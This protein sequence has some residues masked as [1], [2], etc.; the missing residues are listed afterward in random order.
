MRATGNDLKRRLIGLCLVGLFVSLAILPAQARW[1]KYIDADGKLKYRKVDDVTGAPTPVVDPTKISGATATPDTRPEVRPD[2][3]ATGSIRSGI[4]VPPEVLTGTRV[5]P[6]VLEQGQPVTRVAS[7]GTPVGPFVLEAVPSTQPDAQSAAPATQPGG[8]AEVPV[9]QPIAGAATT[10]PAAPPVA[11]TPRTPATTPAAQPPTGIRFVFANEPL[12]NV[13]EFFSRITGLSIL[14]SKPMD[15]Q[16]TVTFYSP[17]AYTVPEALGVLNTILITRGLYLKIESD[18]MVLLPVDQVKSTPLPVYQG[19]LPAGKVQPSEIV[20]VIMPVGRGASMTAMQIKPLLS[21]FGAATA[22]GEGN[23]VLTDTAVNIRNAQNLLSLVMAG[24]SSTTRPAVEL[25]VF[26]MKNI[27]PDEMLQMIQQ[28]IGTPITRTENTPEGPKTIIERKMPGPVVADRRTNSLLVLAPTDDLKLISSIIERLDVAGIPKMDMETKIFTLERVDVNRA[29]DVIRNAFSGLNDQRQDSMKRSYSATAEIRI[30]V[31]PQ[32]RRLIVTA[33]TAR[34]TDIVKLI[35]D[36]E[37]VRQDTEEQFRIVRL[38]DAQANQVA[39]ALRQFVPSQRELRLDIAEDPRHNTLMLQSN[40]TVMMDKA[41]QLIAKIDPKAGTTTKPEDPLAKTIRIVELIAVDANEANQHIQA[42]LVASGKLSD[43]KPIIDCSSDGSAMLVSC[44]DTQWPQIKALI[45]DLEKIAPNEKPVNEIIRLNFQKP[46]DIEK[47]VQQLFGSGGSYGSGRS[48]R[49][50]RQGGSLKTIA[51]D[52]RQVLIVDATPTVMQQVKDL[53]KRLDVRGATADVKA[54]ETRTYQAGSGQQALQT[55]ESLKKHLADKLAANEIVATFNVDEPTATIFVSTRPQD[56][57]TIE[58]KLKEVMGALAPKASMAQFKVEHG[59]AAQMLSLISGV[60]GTRPTGKGAGDDLRV[61][62]DERT[63]SIIAWGTKETLALVD[64]TI[65][66]L[67]VPAGQSNAQ[68]FRAIVLDN[69]D[70]AQVATTL[71]SLFSEINHDRQKE[72]QSQIRFQPDTVSGRLY[73]IADDAAFKQITVLT[74]EIEK[75]LADKPMGIRFVPVKQGDPSAISQTVSQLY[76]R[77]SSRTGQVS[78]PQGIQI[79]PAPSSRSI[80]IKGDP[81]SV[82]EIALMIEKLDTPDTEQQELRT[83]ECA[84]GKQAQTAKEALTRAFAVDVQA[85][86][87][88]ASFEAEPDSALL[89]VTARKD[90]LVRIEAML[91][92]LKTRTQAMATMRQIALKNAD[93]RQLV[94][95]IEQVVAAQGGGVKLA[96]S[97]D[98]RFIVASGSPKDVE[99]AAKLAADFDLPDAVSAP[100]IR[101]LVLQAADPNA[102]AATLSDVFAVTNDLRKQMK[103]PEIRFRG[104]PATGQLFV[105]ADDEA[106]AQIEPVIKKLDIKGR[107]VMRQFATPDGNAWQWVAMLQN[108][109]GS[110][111]GGE[112]LKLGADPMGTSVVAVGSPEQLETVNQLL[113]AARTEN[114]TLKIVKLTTGDAAQMAK[115]VSESLGISGARGGHPGPV[116]AGSGARVTPDTGTNSLIVTG[117]AAEVAAVEKLVADLDK[118]NPNATQV[119]FVK[120]NNMYPSDMITMLTDL[121]GR[122]GGGPP[123]KVSA[124][125]AGSRLVVVTTPTHFETVSK[126]IK[127]LDAAPADPVTMHFIPVLSGKP[128]DIVDKIKP[129]VEA[130]FGKHG[131]TLTPDPITESVIFTGTQEQY[132]YVDSLVSELCKGATSDEG[133]IVTTVIPLGKEASATRMAEAIRSLHQQVEGTPVKVVQFQSGSTSAG[134]VIKDLSQAQPLPSIQPGTQAPNPPTRGSRSRGATS[135]PEGN[136]RS[137]ASGV[138]GYGLMRPFCRGIAAMMLGQT[139]PQPQPQPHPN[140]DVQPPPNP[141]V[142]GPEKPTNGGAHVGTA[143]RM[144]RTTRPESTTPPTIF[145]DQT[146]NSLIVQGTGAQVR[147]IQDLIDSLAE[148]TAGPDYEF[149]VYKLSACPPDSMAD[150]LE[151][152][153]NGRTTNAAGQPQVQIPQQPQQPQQGGNTGG[154][155]GRT[156]GG[157]TGGANSDASG[158][159]TPQQIQ[160]Q[161]MMQ[162]QQMIQQQ[163]QQQQR[164][165]RRIVVVPDLRTN[166]IIVKA[167]ANDFAII[168]PVV[169]AMDVELKGS[170]LEV[171]IFALQNIDAT[172]A[173]RNLK[174]LFRLSSGGGGTETAKELEALREQIIQIAKRGGGNEG[175][176]VKLINAGRMTITANQA[177]NTVVVAAPPEGLTLVKAVLDELDKAPVVPAGS[178]KRIQLANAKAEQLAPMFQTLFV[179][180][181]QAGQQ[182]GGRQQGRPARAMDIGLVVAA[183]PRTNSVLVRAAPS[184]MDEIE[185][186]IKDLDQIGPL[187]SDMKVYPLKNADASM[188][189]AALNQMYRPAAGQQQTVWIAADASSNSVL[190]KAAGPDLERVGKLIEKMDADNASVPQ[191]KVFTLKIAQAADVAQA[192]N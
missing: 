175:E 71:T 191:T 14:G 155:G 46:T 125:T 90:D 128:S 190:A 72:G 83:Y 56:V 97:P 81:K 186:L 137:D 112:Q 98:G 114:V 57:P 169:R 100:N 122:Q 101:M 88:K 18:H 10:Q 95:M 183:D 60:I 23:L 118:A 106:Y 136:V 179:N 30:T 164:L 26:A 68:P 161:Q 162:Q 149:R 64:A 28:L 75:A 51:D 84:T 69:A 5:G 144:P 45:D 167:S 29:A 94:G 82:N 87:M 163:M 73:V 58:A 80:M 113:T 36:M 159:L 77:F 11:V 135:R 59:P 47:A 192:I 143:V 154:R 1:E 123:L 32:F 79:M 43:P 21:T 184:E 92:Q 44:T 34:M 67:D 152:L 127:Q 96:A 173:E 107:S 63:N 133:G 65:K 142:D 180:R 120:L 171:Q 129:Q 22:M 91:N 55:V 156:G 148:S 66:Q 134:I 130:K 177:A 89:F 168:E 126:V 117:P 70:P 181:R 41:M 93:G 39:S 132:L 119:F 52:S 8:V 124:D 6:F 145:V 38:G 15:V 138:G 62:Q 37:K 178:V 76:G 20:T 172:E 49:S 50:S 103:K 110:K 3:R 2:A 53:I 165:S 109:L 115:T 157:R 170:V 35:D 116:V 12:A 188:I 151:R 121:F 7:A 160:Q 31:D 19:T 13:L 176:V 187:D 102:V 9:T 139:D 182:P 131:P 185:K 105:L 99:S 42:H 108:V 54:T 153:F 158:Q 85:G 27:G 25:N 48:G 104:D 141:D 146:T 147:A 78:L 33:T 74:D 174:A 40:S 189:S 61:T 111:A 150:I 86:R 4:G 16:G 24:P 140:P 166:A 17:K